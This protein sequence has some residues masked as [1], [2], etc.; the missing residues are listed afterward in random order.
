MSRI[1]TR[2]LVALASSAVAFVVA[3]ILVDNFS[4]SYPLGLI[5]PVVIFTLAT[6]VVA[7]VADAMLEKYATWASIFLGL[8]VTWLALLITD[9]VTDRIDIE[10]AVSWILATAI[11][12]IASIVTALVM[13]RFVRG[14]PAIKR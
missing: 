3:D 13:R 1:I 10:G 6:L 9:L 8:I 5:V 4:V 12:W 14:D 11:V 7:P 2:L